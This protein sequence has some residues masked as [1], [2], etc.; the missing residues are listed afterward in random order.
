MFGPNLSLERLTFERERERFFASLGRLWALFS[1]MNEAGSPVLRKEITGLNYIF[2][3]VLY[4]QLVIG[5]KRTKIEIW[6]ISLLGR[7]VRSLKAVDKKL[8]FTHIWFYT[9]AGSLV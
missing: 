9:A 5:N 3:R 6:H 2:G 4:M 8:V 1:L 7:R